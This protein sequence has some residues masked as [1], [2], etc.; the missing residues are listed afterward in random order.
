MREY[1]Y[2]RPHLFQP[3]HYRL[4]IFI[5]T[6]VLLLI[7][8]PHAENLRAPF[9]THLVAMD[10]RLASNHAR[11]ARSGCRPNAIFR[12]LLCDDFE[13]SIAQGSARSPYETSKQRK[14]SS[15]VGNGMMVMQSIAYL[16]H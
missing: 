6:L 13:F 16:H 14:M 9:W 15:L 2:R 4:Q 10:S 8:P 5:N 11:F 1:T 12:P 3:P 7:R